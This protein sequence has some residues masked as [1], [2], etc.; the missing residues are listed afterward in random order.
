[1]LEIGSLL[2]GKYKILNKIGQGGMSVVYLAMNEKANK[3]WAIKEMRKEKNKNYEIMKQSLITETN[4]LKELKHPY[5][6]S[7]ADIIESDDTI[8]IVMDYVE[9]RPL[10]D[11]LTE[12]GTI[13]EDK[14][15]DYAIQ[16]CD[17][18]DYLHSQKPP[19]IYRDLKPANIMLR[20]D[21]K[22]TLIDF[23][24]ARKYNYDSV[25]DTT[26][27][28][29]IGYA[30]PEQFAGE[31]LRQTDARTDIYNLG[32]TMYHL[33]TGVNPSEPPYELYPI[34]RWD[35]SLSN[36]LEKI[37]LR[38]TRKDPDKRFNDC[39][40]MSYAL[41][42]FRDLDDS[43]IATQK[44]K[45]FLFAA[46]LILSFTF[47]S[48]AIVVN[49]MEKREISKVYNN[50]L[51][52]AALKI[53]S[54]GSKNVVDTDILKLFKDAINV[55]P[56][57]TEAYIRMLDYYCDLGQTR[58]GLMA[59]SAMIASGTGDLS[60]ND[61]LMMRM[62]QIYFLGNSKDTEFN[63][64]YGTAARYFDKV[65][66]KKY[67]QAKY[68]S[69]LSKSLSEI[70]MDW[71]IIVKDM[72]NV[73]E[74]LNTEVNEEEK[75]EIYI[76]LSKIYRANAFAIQK[77]GE[78]PFDKAM[79]LLNKA[80]EILNSSYTDKNLKDKY[81]PELYFGFADAYYRRANVEPDE[82]ESRNDLYEA[83]SYYERYLIFAT[84]AQTVLFKNRIGDIYRA[85]GEYKRAVEEYED[86]IEKYPEDATAYISLA[87]MLLIDMKD[88]NTSAMI[89][90]KARQLPDIE[91]NS[92]FVS[93]KNKLKNVGGI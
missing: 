43:Y 79:E 71:N 77:V 19:I 15:A 31:T 54:T 78:K 33:L 91:F 57:S 75:A 24:T 74:Y 35:E 30:A 2:D 13:E 56:N 93:L 88:V 47:F 64:D 60:N 52:E 28:G 14:V 38:A 58:N 8:I 17:V 41:Q 62:G 87:T 84:T 10:S 40:E 7:I 21:G 59:I 69:S 55:S 83:V 50:Y 68:Y 5:L 80:G 51:S 1:M 34:R 73:D 11:I 90:M 32:A 12:E 67:P 25:S 39:K 61:D 16:L 82:K 49:G 44:K 48:M 85:L 18:L 92:N 6:P 26:C 65:N 36:G 45:I 20:P 76:T 4:L 22:I 46:S 66:I 42:H 27:L 37:I 81:L 9:G 29:T 70:G 3:Q 23:G 72:K 53:A 86:I 63:I 89:Y